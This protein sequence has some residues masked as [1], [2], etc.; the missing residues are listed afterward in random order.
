MDEAKLRM[1]MLIMFIAFL[2]SLALCITFIIID[3]NTKDYYEIPQYEKEIK[4]E[5][6]KYKRFILNEDY[7]ELS[8][9]AKLH[10]NIFSDEFTNNTELRRSF[11][12]VAKTLRVINSLEN[13]NNDPEVETIFSQIR[14]IVCSKGEKIS[15]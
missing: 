11:M 9:P 13:R 5:F 14:E 4:S 2:V 10:I 1:V 15:V 7:L 12:Q 6:E 8:E 3:H